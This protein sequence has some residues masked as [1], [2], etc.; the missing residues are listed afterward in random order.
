LARAAVACRRV[1]KKLFKINKKNVKNF[2]ELKVTNDPHY[3]AIH[4]TIHR[5]SALYNLV[6]VIN[7]NYKINN[8]CINDPNYLNYGHRKS[9]KVLQKSLPYSSFII[10]IKLTTLVIKNIIKNTQNCSKN[11]FI[12]ESEDKLTVNK[13][14][15]Q[16]SFPCHVIV[17]DA[18]VLLSP[19]VATGLLMPGCSPLSTP[20][21]HDECEAC[22]PSTTRRLVPGGSSSS[23]FLDQCEQGT[24]DILPLG[25]G[26]LCWCRTNKDKLNYFFHTD[27]LCCVL[28]ILL[29]LKYLRLLLALAGDIHPNPG[30]S[31]FNV[32]K[33]TNLVVLT[34]NVQ[35]IK[36]FKKI[37]RVNNFLHRLTFSKNVVINL[38]ETHL[39]SKE[40]SKLDFQWKWGSHHSPAIDNSG[41]VSILYNKSYFDEVFKTK[42]D[43]CGRKC[44]IYARKDDENY[45][46][47]NIYAPNNHYDSVTFFY[48]VGEWLEE[49]FNLDSNINI[50]ISGDY[51]FIINPD[52]DSVG[53][54]QTAQEKRVVSIF[55]RIAT[56]YNLVDSYRLL[57]DYG[58]FTWGRDN[59]KTIRS[60][61]DHIFVSKNIRQNLLSCNTNIQ[62]NE[63]D[64]RTVYAEFQIDNQKYG[65]GIV[66]GN[67]NLLDNSDIKRKVIS[68]LKRETENFPNSWNAHTKLDYTKYKLRDLLLKEGKILARRSESK[69][70]YINEELN[71]LTK[72]LDRQVGKGQENNNTTD[73]NNIDRLKESIDSL[74]EEIDIIKD[75]ESSK[76]IF[77]SRAK[78]AEK[79]EKS[80]KYFLNLLKARQKA[81]IIRKIISNGTVSYKQDEISKAIKKFYQ[82]LYK[83]QPDLK[84]PDDSELFKDLPTI[85]PEQNKMLSEPL[86]LSELW[87]TLGTCDESAPGPDGLSYKVL[88]HT[89]DIIGPLILESWRCSQRCGVASPSQRSSVIT[90]L[91]KKGKDKAK[92]ENLRPISL[93]NCD[94]KLCTKALAIRTN[95]VLPHILSSTQTGYVPGRQVN[96]NSRLLEEIINSCKKNKEQGYLITLDAR[97][98]FDSVDHNYLFH[99]LK[100]FNFPKEYIDN[101]RML[102]RDLE[103][104][105]LVNGFTTDSIN[106]EQSVKQGDALSCALFIIAIEPLLR[107]INNNPNIKGFDIKGNDQNL[108]IKHMSYADD[109]TALCKNIEGIQFIIDEYLRFSQYSG[110]KLNIEKTEIMII[111][112]LNEIPTT[113][114]IKNSN[115][116]IKIIDSKSVKI[117]GITFSNSDECAYQ[118]NII[119]KIDKLERQLNIWRQRNL[120][121]QGKILI[122]KTYGLSQLVY[123]LQA[124]QI[125]TKE[126]K[127]IEDIIFRFIWN[128]KQTNNRCN[129]KLKR[130]IMY[131]NIE[132]GGLGAP[133]VDKLNRAIKLKHIIR[134]QSNPHPVSLITN[135]EL[136][137]TGFS[138]TGFSK[139]VKSFS[140]YVQSALDTNKMLEGLLMNDIKI[141]SNEET[142]INSY[143]YI[144]IQNHNIE[145]SSL[146]NNEMLNSIK[147]L[148]SK[149]IHTL[150]DVK[151]EKDL[152]T[153]NHLI[154][155]C[156]MVLSKVPREWK[157]LLNK[158]R[159]THSNTTPLFSQSIN[160]CKPSELITQKEIYTRLLGA[161]FIHSVKSYLETKHNIQSEHIGKAFTNIIRTTRI[162]SLQ[163]VQFKLLHNIYP[164]Q[165]HLFKWNIKESPLCGHCGVEETLEH[166]IYSCEIANKTFKNLESVVTEHTQITLGLTY[167]DILAG[168]ACNKQTRLMFC[169]KLL[170][171]ELIIIIKRK[172]ILQRE[173]K[174]IL[175]KPELINI[176]KDHYRIYKYNKWKTN[177][178]NFFNVLNQNLT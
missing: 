110:I 87:A 101:V 176:I 118:E 58:G 80:N 44:A 148:S 142:G 29:N 79:G 51:N 3:E 70:E 147:R 97:K 103:A 134:C 73:I 157:L 76:L 146:L 109:I 102:Y 127:K 105:I 19:R 28:C 136:K 38:Q 104:S 10:Q 91:E 25:V 35:G 89:W 166:A 135:A 143:Y 112:K 161:P 18:L 122:V 170:L 23:P 86:T 59:P 67:S 162:K 81:M 47:L 95:K 119:D 107:Q 60:R 72:E 16:K 1:K 153:Y 55:K 21:V 158:A 32:H 37:K 68:E 116:I 84:K 159:K 111:G 165:R 74:K 9:T 61:L 63:S 173:E 15:S 106:I 124:T 144:L 14:Q 117:C 4:V 164:T 139:T 151:R 41:G 52:I 137:R 69:L 48:S 31:S 6:S 141:M 100:L 108:E 138:I 17:A 45:F 13:V 65:P 40:T 82:T 50:I 71:T 20:R 64:H 126:L 30:P 75:E 145:N 174:R 156:H 46:F 152:P 54:S 131:N 90:L 155:D 99:I 2:N 62:P 167:I 175:E 114:E 26:E 78:W 92:I 130:K 66:R 115:D 7:P 128:V 11:R 42:T 160:K 56:K 22:G 133:N 88:K 27:Y 121:L 178:W 154:M 125:F 169:E 24:C 8:F 77:R 123:S 93:S 98:A 168:I 120:T 177:A 132:A 12:E 140:N 129:D 34:Y 33:K 5:I 96:D 57:N 171:D 43:N 53:R 85:T 113:F 83:K 150:N 49:A 94:I 36:N 39:N 163:N 149:G 172:L